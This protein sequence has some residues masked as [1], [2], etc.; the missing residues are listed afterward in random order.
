MLSALAVACKTTAPTARKAAPAEPVI[1]TLG[2]KGFTTDDFF[3]SFTK[4]QISGDSSQRTDLK[5]YLD[6]YANLKLKVL[7]AEQEGRD[8]TEAFREELETYRKQLAQSY[9]TDKALVEQ[10]SAEAYQ[11]MQEEVNASHILIAVAE[12]ASPA[13][14]LAA[15]QMARSLRDRLLKGEEFAALARQYS[16]DPTVAQNGGTIGYF[17]AFQTVYPFE[18]TAYT[19]PVGKISQPVRS[20]SGYHL[21]KVN[22]RRSSR[23]KIQVAH[24]MVRI[25]PGADDAG[26]AAAK[27]RIDEVYSRL[28][29]GV[30]F[31]ALAKEFSDDTQSRNNGGLLPTFA[32]GQMVPAFEDAAFGLTAPGS[33]SKPVKTNYGWHILKLVE[34][35]PLEPYTE[36]APALR[37][38]VVTDSRADLIRQATVQRL[39]KEYAI[40]PN[41]PVLKAALSKADSSLLQGKWTYP[42]PLDAA[43]DG[44]TLVIINNKPATVNQ[45]FTYVRQKQQPR[46]AGAVP[47]VAMQRLFD[48]FVGDQLIAAEEANLENKHADFRALLNEVRDGVLLSQMMEQN[49]WEKSMA[50][51]LG[52]RQFYEQNR[53]K[54]GFPERAFATVVVAGNDETL[55]QARQMLAS[56]P[57]QLRRSAPEITYARNQTTLEAKQKEAL[58]DILVTL[59]RNPEYIIEVSGSREAAEKDS[60]SAGRIHAVVNYLTANG[61]S[62]MRI[63]EKDHGAFRPGSKAG[64][65]DAADQRRITFQYFS[66]SKKDVEKVL[67]AKI[68]NAVTITEGAFVEGANPHLDSVEWKP[69]TTVLH[70]DNKSV[71]VTINRVE[72]PRL[73]TFEEARGAVIN[74][75][76]AFLEKQWLAQLK[77]RFPVKINE[78]EM[79]KLIK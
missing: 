27:A 66:T 61:V 49:V 38:K 43:L 32:T 42:Q 65:K 36:L 8:T 25:S 28:Q 5:S 47:T 37:Q 76:Q 59:L 45:F 78:E 41:E 2:N 22:D 40:K 54:Y 33:Y 68:P 18:T 51:S 62:V 13:D 57:Y 21:I 9:L 52:Q 50:D 12:D 67:N 39:Q 46:P 73:K 16:K 26:Q 55:Q 53:Q 10:L 30:S 19:T 24:I 31:D 14:T 72:K 74:D 6:L 58:F 75:Y 3:Q 20:R 17:S 70:P 77:Q 7:A 23:G 29:K 44:K 71:M 63:M 34:R 1:L 56:S 60:V 48:R 69:G 15:F 11:R 79:R 4:N 35:K 64:A